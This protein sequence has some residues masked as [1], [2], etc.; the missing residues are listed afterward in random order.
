MSRKDLH[1]MEIQ[2]TRRIDEIAGEAKKVDGEIALL[3]EKARSPLSRNEE[4]SLARRIKTL[5]QKKDMKLRRSG[6]ARQRAQSGLEY[7]H[8][9]RARGRSEVCRDMEP[10]KGSGT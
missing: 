1:I 2:L 4:I 5:S 6:P 10:G 8:P 3:L 9:Q 7:T